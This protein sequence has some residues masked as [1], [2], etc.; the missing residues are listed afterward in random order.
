VLEPRTNLVEQEKFDLVTV[1]HSI[2][3]RRR[4][5]FTL[6]LNVLG[7]NDVRQTEIHTSE[8]LLLEPSA[9]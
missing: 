1:S 2:L 6:L 7:I 4:K 5:H 3:A 9:F 8:P